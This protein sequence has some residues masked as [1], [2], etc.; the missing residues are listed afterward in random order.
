MSTHGPISEVVAV[1][2]WFVAIN[3][4]NLQAAR[5]A[6]M[7]ADRSQMD[8]GDGTTSGWA[9]FTNVQCSL[10]TSTSTSA[11]VHCTSRESDAADTGNPGTFWN[12][13]VTL[14]H[15]RWLIASYGQG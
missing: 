8:W 3:Q 9:T 7:P 4:K 6:F 10:L 2:S 11:D 15:G 12:V 5:N 14:S 13:E 1:Q